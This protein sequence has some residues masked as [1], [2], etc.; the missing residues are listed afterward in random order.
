[1]DFLLS[2][3]APFSYN[4]M[5]KKM[6]GIEITYVVTT[7]ANIIAKCVNS[8]CLG[9]LSIIFSQ[10]GDTLGTLALVENADSNSNENKS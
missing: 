8:E 6:S 3:N 9:L 1:M 4:G 10:L 2:K 7:L 5:V